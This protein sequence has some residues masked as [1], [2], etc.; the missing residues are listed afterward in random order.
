MESRDTENKLVV[1]KEEMKENLPVCMAWCMG[2]RLVL[3]LP[4]GP[5]R[6]AHCLLSCGWE[7]KSREVYSLQQEGAAL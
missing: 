5:G 7:K 6:L 1:T 2:H 4:W 3:G